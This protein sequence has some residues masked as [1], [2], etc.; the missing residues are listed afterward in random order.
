M[1]K[2]QG[3]R[4]WRG[5][6]VPRFKLWLADNRV[7][8]SLSHRPSPCAKVQPMK[9]RSRMTA[10][11]LWLFT[12]PLMG[13]K[14]PSPSA[15]PLQAPRPTSGQAVLS[16]EVADP[17]LAEFKDYL[18]AQVA[19]RIQKHGIAVVSAE[20]ADP[21]RAYHLGIR[22]TSRKTGVGH[23]QFFVS[24]RTSLLKDLNLGDSM[25]A[26]LPAVWTWD[27]SVTVR[28]DVALQK[29]TLEGTCTNVLT[30]L[31]S[32]AGLS[33]KP[34]E[35]GAWQGLASGVVAVGGVVGESGGTRRVVDFDFRQIKIKH[36]PPPP[37]YPPLAKIAAIQGTVVVELVIDTDGLTEQATAL[38]GPPQLRASAES[39]AMQWRFE[40]ALLN[41]APQKARFRLTMPFRLRG[42]SPVQI[43]QAALELVACD[44]ALQGLVPELTLEAREMLTR[45]GVTRVEGTEANLGQ[46]H[47]LQVQISKPAYGDAGVL[48][49]VRCFLRKDIPQASV[50][51][52]K[53]APLR[54]WQMYVLP[55]M[56][57][58]TLKRELRRAFLDIVEVPPILPRTPPAPGSR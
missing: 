24:G 7:I 15:T 16:L 20:E 43:Q 11:S 14:P 27:Q 39:F 26:A 9:L 49:S 3:P 13:Q 6:R 45:L 5:L 56:D 51:P 53:L 18:K 47:H 4:G 58:A 37:P 38:D 41:N 44:P 2:A 1:P 25:P 31:L 28:A 32:R 17:A 55:G 33:E 30:K 35:P 8:F 48:L 46:A 29:S 57:P 42:G 21:Q 12:C 22:I 10:V 50:D 52:V 54:S 23:T 19:Q 40:P 34:R 36:Q